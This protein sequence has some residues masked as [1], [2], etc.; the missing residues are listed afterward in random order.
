MRGILVAVLLFVL[1][2]AGPLVLERFV[3]DVSEVW[4]RIASIGC[5]VIALLVAI[6]SDPLYRWIKEFRRYS[7]VST[8]IVAASFGVMGAAV[9]LFLLV[10]FPSSKAYLQKLG[11]QLGQASAR[12]EKPQARSKSGAPELSLS[13]D[14]VVLHDTP[15]EKNAAIIEV[16]AGVFNRGSP[17]TA[18]DWKLRV[19]ALGNS[20]NA[21]YVLGEEPLPPATKITVAKPLDE[22]LSTNA[23]GTN[24][25]VFGAVKFLIHGVAYQELI[26]AATIEHGEPFTI[27]LS[28][29]DNQNKE[30]SVEQDIHKLAVQPV[31]P[32]TRPPLP[33]P[34]TEA[35]P[36]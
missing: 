24:M 30:W 8:M 22:M 31:I 5:L 21:V 23:L 6:L 12:S 33:T 34:N 2:F 11:N 16:R 36:P 9:W 4:W 35:S 7:F 26:N 25:G 14:T 28:V 17:S 3:K 13:L 15:A 1:A 10:G 29:Q 27:R 32:M 19:A 18:H 20:Y